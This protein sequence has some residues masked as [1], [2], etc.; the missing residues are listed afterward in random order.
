[1]MMITRETRAAQILAI[2]RALGESRRTFAA[3]FGCSRRTVESWEQGIR[4]PHPAV[5]AILAK[6]AKR[7]TVN[8]LQQL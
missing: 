2:R 3:R 8:S 4:T 1:M 5:C 6:L 7:C